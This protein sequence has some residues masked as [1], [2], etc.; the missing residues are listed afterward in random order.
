[1]QLHF[2]SVS[3]VGIDV[4]LGALPFEES[5][6]ARANRFAF[7]GDVALR[8]CSAEDLVVLKAFAA[9][10]DDPRS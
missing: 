9:L 1:M 3:G 6:V 2:R 4:A 5:V 7:P 10:K 8:T